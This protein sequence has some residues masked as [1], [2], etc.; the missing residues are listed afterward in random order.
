MS[1][2]YAPDRYFF[3]TMWRSADADGT[4]LSLSRRGA[5][6]QEVSPMRS[7]SLTVIGLTLLLCGLRSADVTA[8]GLDSSQVQMYQG[9]PSLSGGIGEEERETLRRLAREYNVQLIFAAKEGHYVA[10]VHVTIADE[11]GS[12]VLEAVSEGPWLYT[13]LPAGTY[14][15]MAQVNGQTQ[16]RVVHVGQQHQTPPQ[17]YW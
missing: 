14:T 16:R 12:T 6:A 15:I 17:F 4:L 8:Q 11:R 9:I 10:E 7:H 3:G 5:Q 13:K 2:P 1:P